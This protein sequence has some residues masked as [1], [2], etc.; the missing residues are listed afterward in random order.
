MYFLSGLNYIHAECHVVYTGE[1]DS[2]IVSIPY[3]T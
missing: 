3:S 2:M 1:S